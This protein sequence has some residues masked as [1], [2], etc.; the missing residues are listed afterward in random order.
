MLKNGLGLPVV[1]MI[2]MALL[3]ASC[4]PAGEKCPAAP[5]TVIIQFIFPEYT[6]NPDPVIE[7]PYGVNS[8]E[9]NA[10]LFAILE[11]RDYCGYEFLD[12]YKA[13]VYYDSEGAFYDHDIYQMIVYQPTI[14]EWFY[15]VPPG[16]SLPID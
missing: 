2:S 5:A 8:D 7:I 9:W 10:N 16:S 1:A 14:V 15:V 6:K 13:H 4:A 3:T 11:L 12:G